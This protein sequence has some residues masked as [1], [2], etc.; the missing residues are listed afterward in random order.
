M[1]RLS[2]YLVTLL[3]C[4]MVASV[5]VQGHWAFGGEGEAVPPPSLLQA[6]SG[7]YA[8][9]V[10]ADTSDSVTTAA[11]ISRCSG[12]GLIYPDT[13]SMVTDNLFFDVSRD[14]STWVAWVDT[15]GTAIRVT[16]N[17]ASGGFISLSGMGL[18]A[19]PGY[20]RIQLAAGDTCRGL[21]TFYFTYRQG[22]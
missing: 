7:V 3:L 11:A 1:R 8:I 17:Q 10:T 12:L 2:G 13:T 16:N 6:P 22:R 19:A 5:A 14:G 9:P 18:L 4:L 20:L 21:K 15:S